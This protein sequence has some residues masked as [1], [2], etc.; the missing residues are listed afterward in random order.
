[1]LEVENKLKK[2]QQGEQNFRLPDVEVL[3]RCWLRGGSYWILEVL[4]CGCFMLE[5]LEEWIISAGFSQSGHLVWGHFEET[6][7]T[8]TLE[9]TFEQSGSY[10]YW[11]PNWFLFL[12]KVG[13]NVK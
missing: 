8:I 9:L 7:V 11:S 6:S 1:M 13:G 2:E 4:K 10:A 12:W 5:H 3:A